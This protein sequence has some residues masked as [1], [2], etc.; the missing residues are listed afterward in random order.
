MMATK[1]R[2]QC[3]GEGAARAAL[4]EEEAA[5]RGEFLRHEAPPWH[6]NPAITTDWNHRIT[7]CIARVLHTLGQVLDLVPEPAH[8][9]PCRYTKTKIRDGNLGRF[10]GRVNSHPA[11]AY[12]GFV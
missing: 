6:I 11:W 2:M 8:S 5:A 10:Y 3:V 1:K 9:Q 12:S 4:A 7:T